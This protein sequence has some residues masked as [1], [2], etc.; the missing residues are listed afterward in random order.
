MLTCE[1]VENLRAFVMYACGLKGDEKGEAQV[2]CDRLLRVFG[3]EGYKEAGTT[4]R[5]QGAKEGKGTKC[6]DLLWRPRLLLERRSAEISCSVTT[7][8]P[9]NIGFS[10][11]PRGRA[12]CAERLLEG[13]GYAT[14]S[15]FSC[16][17]VCPVRQLEHS[18]GP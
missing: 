4:S 11:F 15:A 10:S 16:G 17:E 2:F 12:T 5:V 6:A 3:F 18:V 7:A 9:L 1:T 13:L 8:K 14:R